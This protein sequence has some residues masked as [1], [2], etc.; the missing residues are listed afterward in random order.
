MVLKASPPHNFFINMPSMG[1][2]LLHRLALTI[3]DV[4]QV[5]WTL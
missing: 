3:C 5:I 1:Y 2:S 4:R